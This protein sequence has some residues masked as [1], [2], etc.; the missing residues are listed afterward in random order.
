[1]K[2]TGPEFS[3]GAVLFR[4]DPDGIRYLIIEGNSGHIAFP[5]GHMEEGETDPHAV[6]AREIREETG[7]TSA[8][9]VDGFAEEYHCISGHGNPKTVTYYLAE[10]PDTAVTLQVEEVKNYWFLPFEQAVERVNTP[11]EREILTAANALLTK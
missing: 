11:R 5:K 8:R 2:R 6:A 4:R 1:M 10:I 7:I 3:Y 9:F